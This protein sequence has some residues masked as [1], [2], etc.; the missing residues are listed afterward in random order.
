V[1]IGSCLLL[2][3]LAFL[4]SALGPL[5][6]WPAGL[7]VWLGG[8]L[9]FPRADA[10]TR[11]LSLVLLAA[12]LVALTVAAGRG[13]EIEPVADLTRMAT[14][15]LPIVGLFLGVAFLSLVGTPS[16]PADAGAKVVGATH[17]AHAAATRDAAEN[18]SRLKP[19]PQQADRSSGTNASAESGLRPQGGLW[20]TLAAIHLVGAVINLSM[21]AMSGD[22]MSRERGLGRREAIVLARGHCAAAFWSPFF[23]A[24]AVA[25]TYAP[26]ADAAITVPL[27][28]IGALLAL[29]L[30][31]LDARRALTA[32]E[33]ATP[34]VG[35]V[36]DRHALVLTGALLA[37]ALGLK[38]V[39]ADVPMV[40]VVTAV[41]PPLA[42][43][44]MPASARPGAL[45]R[46]LGGTLPATIGQVVLFLA[47]GV[48]AFGIARTIRNAIRGA[49]GSANGS[50][51]AGGQRISASTSSQNP[52]SR[53][54][55]LRRSSVR[56]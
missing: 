54:E 27:G 52:S 11:R 43:L 53:R 13:G 18:R 28:I 37:A 1:L 44:L 23:V 15:N 5:P 40:V 41:T 55:R 51:D 14:I 2:G 29:L 39:L 48:F 8:L 16:G 42:L 21:T 17:G 30:T 35:I 34:F 20:S 19:L 32:E 47:A 56:P 12:G 6:V 45:G 24:A 7:L 38:M 9:G 3:M 46:L 26:E 22:R 31:G 4:G 25:H 49:V 33:R 50:F 10:A 36:P